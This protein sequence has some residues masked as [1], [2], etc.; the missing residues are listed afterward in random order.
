MPAPRRA[1]SGPLSI[2]R[3]MLRIAAFLAAA[4]T[5]GISWAGNLELLMFEQDG[6][7]YCLRW[8]EEIG[9]AY[10]RTSEGA[11]APLR[12]INLRAQLPK[13]V[14]LTARHPVFTPTFVLLED[15]TEID[16]IEGYAGD[17]FFWVLLNGM[18]TR[19]GWRPDDAPPKTERGSNE[20]ALVEP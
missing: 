14:T 8:H 12:R 17:E 3:T 5:A 11:S 20:D 2:F 4:L 19:T 10:P 15:G 9:P 16:R 7:A 6:C 1:I 13:D 18:L